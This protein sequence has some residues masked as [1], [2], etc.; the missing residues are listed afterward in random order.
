MTGSPMVAILEEAFAR[1][2]DEP[3]DQRRLAPMR[4]VVLELADT[5]I[6]EATGWR[7]M[8]RDKNEPLA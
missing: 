8:L 1:A 4:D 2:S 7:S 5:V 6:E 3:A